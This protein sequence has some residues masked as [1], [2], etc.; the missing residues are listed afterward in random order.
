MRWLGRLAPIVVVAVAATAG[1]RVSG[2][3]PRIVQPGAPGQPSRGVTADQATDLSHVRSSAADARFMEGMIHHHA[4]ALAMTGLVPARGAS[5]DMRMLAQRIEVSQ[6]DE[7]RM[8]ERWL[9]ARG[10]AVPGAHSHDGHT[11]AMPGMAT[12]EEMGRLARASGS[13]FDR[14]FLELMIRHHEGALVMVKELFSTPGAGQESEIFAF[15][16]DVVADQRM[17]IQRMDAMLTELGR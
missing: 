5:A 7:I 13:E 8:M 15:A 3:S 4:Q 2:T 10:H 14:L 11:A 1:C 12:A 9:E 17:E 6:A 16:S